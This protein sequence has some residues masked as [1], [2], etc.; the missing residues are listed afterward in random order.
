LAAATE[1]PH[2]RPLARSTSRVVLS[3]SVD[4]ATQRHAGPV[5][6]YQTLYGCWSSSSE[7]T[8]KPR[9]LLETSTAYDLAYL[10]I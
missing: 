9:L 5:K 4:A 8:G 1:V 3:Q 6:A 2:E 7:R 10:T